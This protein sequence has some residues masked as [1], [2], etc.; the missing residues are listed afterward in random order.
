M[1]A[2]SFTQRSLSSRSSASLLALLALGGVLQ[3]TPAVQGLSDTPRL[4]QQH[5][6][7]LERERA[8]GVERVELGDGRYQLQ[9][10]EG[11][12]TESV[13]ERGGLHWVYEGQEVFTDLPDEGLRGMVYLQAEEKKTDLDRLLGS[14]AVDNLGRR[15]SLDGVD[16]LAIREAIAAYDELVA[17]EFGLEEVDASPVPEVDDPEPGGWAY[18]RDLSWTTTDC[19]GDGE[20]DIFRYGA[21]DRVVSSN[22]MTT[23]QKKVV[24]IS[25]PGGTGSGVMVDNEWLL[26]A[27][28]VITTSGGTAYNPSTYDI[29]TLGN[30]QTG[31]QYFDADIAVIPGGY[32]GDGDLNDDYAVVHLT[33]RPGVGW[34]AISSASNSTIRRADS[35]NCGYPSYGPGC[36]STSVTKIHSDHVAGKQYWSKG[37]LFGTTSNKIKTRLDIATGHSGGPFYYYPSGCCGAHY[38]T[39]VCAAYVNPAIGSSYTGGPK[40]SAIRSWVIA[41]T[42]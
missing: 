16:E 33:S 22:P 35:Y 25:C 2:N 32:T 28:H 3:A 37:D 15:W 34:M 14:V 20:D 17:S 26:T 19:D 1:R 10:P 29:C 21:D 6:R 18:V 31:A 24:L 40:G 39:G 7:A 27:A 30:Y 36:S 42:P 13:R 4:R 5:Q 41:T 9:L 23:R 38:V 8:L 11:V 12:Q